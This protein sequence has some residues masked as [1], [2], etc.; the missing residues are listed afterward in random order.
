MLC[1]LV[2]LYAITR[3]AIFLIRIRFKFNRGE[4][5]KYISHLDLMRTFERALR[6]ANIPVEY[7]QGYNPHPNLVFG[8]PLPVGVT[9][10]AEYADVG[11][12]EDL[13]PDDFLLRLNLQLPEDL[14]LTDAKEIRSKTNIMASIAFASYNIK[15]SANLSL[16][17]FQTRLMNFVEMDKIIVEKESK[18]AVKDIDIRPLIHKLEIIDFDQSNGRGCISALLSAGSVANLRPDLMI[19]ALKKYQMPEA[20]LE[21]IHRTGLYLNDQD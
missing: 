21:A 10:A 18:R 11:L 8:L 4:K 7:S 15:L 6:R 19:E 14:R 20:K 5:V 9:S 12:T 17:E 16:S 1:L 2:I 13:S 3:E